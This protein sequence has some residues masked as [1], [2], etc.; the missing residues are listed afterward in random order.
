M[1]SNEM[2]DDIKEIVERGFNE[3]GEISVSIVINILVEDKE[4]VLDD[5]EDELVMFIEDEI[6]RVRKEYYE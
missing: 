3:S 4:Y 2:K 1:L 5:N 6:V